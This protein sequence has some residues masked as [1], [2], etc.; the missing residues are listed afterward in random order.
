MEPD[1]FKTKIWQAAKR[2]LRSLEL[3]QYDKRYVIHLNGYPWQNFWSN[4][5]MIGFHTW[6]KHVLMSTWTGFQE[7]VPKILKK[8]RAKHNHATLEKEKASLQKQEVCF[9]YHQKNLTLQPIYQHQH[10]STYQHTNTST[11]QHINTSTHQHTDILA[12]V[13]Q[14]KWHHSPKSSVQFCVVYGFG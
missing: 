5:H 14:Q 12:Q 9:C 1:A 7:F 11:H 13:H 6:R 8:L 10:D 2:D 3:L 4:D